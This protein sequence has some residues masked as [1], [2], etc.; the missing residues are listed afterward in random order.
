MQQTTR[1]RVR[2]FRALRALC[3]WVATVC[4]MMHA[5]DA[6]AQTCFGWNEAR[7]PSE[8]FSHAMAYDSVRNVVLMVSGRFDTFEGIRDTWEWNGRAW[9]QR[10]TSNLVDPGARF[11]HAIAFDLARGRTVLFGGRNLG[12]TAGDTWE[13]D[14]ARWE[15]RQL[16]GGPTARD[17]HAMAYDPVRRE[18]ILFGGFDGSNDGET[19]A[20]NGTTWTL[21]STTGPSP[22]VAHAMVFDDVRGVIVLFGGVG[23]GRF[24]DTWEWNGTT[25]TLRA[26]NAGP[27]ARDSHTMAYDPVRGETLL[28]GGDDGAFRQDTW[29]WN[30]TTWTQRS[31]TGPD[32]CRY[33][34]MV[35]DSARANV[36]L[37]GGQLSFSPGDASDRTWTWNGSSWT[38]ITQ[39][40]VP[41]PRRNP[42]V[43]FEASTGRTI[44]F[45]GTGNGGA[46]FNDTWSFD[47]FSWTQVATTGPS[48]REG[49]NLTFD[50][51]RNRIVLFGGGTATG[52]SAET[53]EWDGSA[54]S[55]RSLVG[56]SERAWAGLA[57]DPV[58]NV[59]VLFGGSNST[60]DLNDTWEW[61]GVTWTLRATTGPSRRSGTAMAWDPVRQSVLMFSG[62]SNNVPVGRDTWEWNGSSWNLI[63]NSTGPSAR[64]FHSMITDTAR[65]V[66][67]L[68]GGKDSVNLRSDVW[69]WDGT[70]WTQRAD[71]PMRRRFKQALSYDALRNRITLFG[72]ESDNVAILDDS[73]VFSNSDPVFFTQPEPLNLDPGQIARFRVDAGGNP[74][75]RYQWRRNGVPLTN[76]V[77]VSGA[78]TAELV[79]DGVEPLDAGT[80]SCV[81][82]ND[83]AARASFGALLSVSCPADFDGNGQLDLFDYLDYVQAFAAGCP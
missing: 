6:Q 59:S 36:V 24:R 62:G 23:G 45:G 33:A 29:A 43:A 73:W 67:V 61:N 39:P 55:L 47:G 11:G 60:T 26:N 44:L 42:G 30:G 46:L 56:P 81:V 79:I 13:W 2:G 77:R 5:V 34:K 64:F 21:R 3:A 19:W 54:W 38:R 70:A 63:S 18:T 1:W 20:W 12:T 80:Y 28:F 71:G 78:T 58:R 75:L 22:R 25:W 51:A 32:P 65:N 69:E 53:W 66:L 50:A 31:A 7:P 82:T 27:S 74:P 16:A 49:A 10:R 4:T 8:R 41:T 17:Q 48:P 15:L 52:Q 76:G 9:A 40:G 72:G 35:F 37:F 14:G 68:F 83:C 57:F